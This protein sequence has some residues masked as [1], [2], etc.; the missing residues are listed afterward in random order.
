MDGLE[1]LYEHFWWLA[2]SALTSIASSCQ[3]SRPDY[4]PNT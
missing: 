2:R 3:H 4:D 1:R